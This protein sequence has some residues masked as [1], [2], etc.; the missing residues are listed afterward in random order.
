MTVTICGL[1]IYLKNSKCCMDYTL[2]LFKHVWE[3]GFTK[4]AKTHNMLSVLKS[5]LVS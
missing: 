5:P 3:Y 2:H 4:P 1:H